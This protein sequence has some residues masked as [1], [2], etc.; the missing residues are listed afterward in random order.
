MVVEVALALILMVG[1]GLMLKSFHRL[2]S[3]DSGFQPEQVV[4]FEVSPVLLDEKAS[5]AAERSRTFYAQFMRT[6]RRRCQA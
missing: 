1:A 4:V 6:D 3:V 2:L 5:T